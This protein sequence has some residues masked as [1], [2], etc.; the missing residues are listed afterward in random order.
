M[1]KFS[2]CYEFLINEA[3]NNGYITNDDFSDAAFDFG[4]SLVEST[5]LNEQLLLNGIIISDEPPVKSNKASFDYS[6]I[7]YDLIYGEII[8]LDPELEY[9]VNQIRK[10]PTPQ[11]GEIEELYAK[12]EYFNFDET[13]IKETRERLIFMHM[14]MVLKTALSLSKQFDYDIS[15]AV[16]TGMSALVSAVDKYEPKQYEDNSFGSYVN[17]FVWGE[18][19]R[20]CQP[21]WLLHRVPPHAMEKL[22]AMIRAYKDYYG[23]SAELDVPDDDF[24][25]AYSEQTGEFFECIKSN[26]T[27][28]VNEKNHLSFEEVTKSEDEY[29]DERSFVLNPVLGW[30][31]EI[32]RQQ[33][34][35]K[36]RKVLLTLTERYLQVIKLRYGFENG[37]SMTLDE[38]GT[39]FNVTKER[40][41]QIERKVLRQLSKNPKIKALKDED[42]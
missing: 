42:F 31:E 5:K 10:M 39:M 13:K 34:A 16:F 11:K 7:D 28:I 6:K 38:I 4:L 21:R 27:D 15:D 29:L 12:T 1:S 9:F 22:Y 3:H 8:S 18:I 37:V 14:R 35:E 24:L 17:Q 20:D 23:I 41:R 26:F 33:I 25:R 2:E 32:Y 30:D 36:V 40:I 19:L